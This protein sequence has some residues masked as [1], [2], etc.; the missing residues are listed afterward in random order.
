MLKNKTFLRRIGSLKSFCLQILASCA[1]FSLAVLLAS[2]AQGVKDLAEGENDRGNQEQTAFSK[3]VSLAAAITSTIYIKEGENKI[4]YQ[5]PFSLFAPKNVYHGSIIDL[6]FKQNN[7]DLLNDGSSNNGL[8]SSDLLNNVLSRK[9]SPH[10][11]RMVLRNHKKPDFNPKN[12]APEAPYKFKLIYRFNPDN[13]DK[14]LTKSIQE[15]ISKVL[16]I[17]GLK[18]ILKEIKSSALNRDVYSAGEIILS[19][20]ERIFLKRGE[21]KSS[22]M[23]SNVW[24]IHFSREHSNYVKDIIF[25]LFEH[26]FIGGEA[27]EQQKIAL[28]KMFDKKQVDANLQIYN[29]LACTS[30]VHPL[31][32][33]IM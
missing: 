32:C 6:V 16:K 5:S 31:A 7:N 3:N 21:L 26:F 9:N 24:K 10:V 17:R 27:L 23:I 12:L 25:L 28:N 11:V 22:G 8:I 18:N 2:G 13:A 29:A 19:S 1:A 4:I 14:N 33:R 20:E 15:Q 30:I